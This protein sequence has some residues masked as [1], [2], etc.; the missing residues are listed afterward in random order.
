MQRTSGNEQGCV[1]THTQRLRAEDV[2]RIHG[3]NERIAVADY[4]Q[5]VRFYHQLVSN[6]AISAP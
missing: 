6:A 1:N 4:A 3:V 5:S 2:S